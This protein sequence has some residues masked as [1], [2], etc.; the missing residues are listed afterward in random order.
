MKDE[1]LAHL[2]ALI[3]RQTLGFS[4]AMVG[5]NLPVLFEKSGRHPGQIAG[6]SPYLQAV[7]AEGPSSLIGKVA[8]VAIESRRSQ[9]PRRT[10]ARDAGGRPMA[11]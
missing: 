10:L 5:R 3:A 1:R 2:Q 6:R 4:R 7:H 9:Q 8:E 11:G